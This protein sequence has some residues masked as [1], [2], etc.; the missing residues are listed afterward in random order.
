M[1]KNFKSGKMQSYGQNFLRI[2]CKLNYSNKRT[3]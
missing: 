1:L 2:K 3:E